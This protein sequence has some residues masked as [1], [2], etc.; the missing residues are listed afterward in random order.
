M[1]ADSKGS[2]WRAWAGSLALHVLV[3]AAIALAV[4]WVGKPEP[5]AQR[6]AIEGRIVQ[7]AP[8]QRRVE[9]PAPEP[10]A[11]PPE[12]EATPEP[13]PEPKTDPKQVEEQRLLAQ[14]A[15]EERQERERAQREKVEREKAEREK[16]E[17]EQAERDKAEKEREAR[18]KAQRE[19]VE[20]EKAAEA[21]RQKE[22]EA[23]L[24][25]Q[26]AAEERQASLRASGMMNQYVAQITAAIER[27]WTRPASARAGLEC[28]VRVT[29]VPGGT[30]TD[31]RV[32]RCNG[33]DAVRNS[34]EAA[35]FK[36]SPLPRPPD[37][38]LF[39][40]NLIVTFRPED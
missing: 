36:A 19:K 34:I 33:D 14:K 29:Q 37:P 9:R 35:V 26:I 16:A 28:E 22:R 7:S 6:L 18:E 8:A 10:V 24:N 31:V 12:P 40:R 30:V 2:P 17:R 13:E 38:A 39:E 25:A 21:A 11:A 32:G 20:R 4:I 1:K 3:V 27:N 23:E 5:V 15:E